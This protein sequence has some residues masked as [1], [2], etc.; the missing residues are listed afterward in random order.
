M[1]EESRERV[2]IDD[3]LILLM[4]ITGHGKSSIANLILDQKKF[5]IHEFYNDCLNESKVESFEHNG[6]KYKILDTPGINFMKSYKEMSVIKREI[7]SNLIK[8]ERIDCLLFVHKYG[9]GVEDIRELIDYIRYIFGEKIVENIIIVITKYDELMLRKD[10]EKKEELMRS[11]FKEIFMKEELPISFVFCPDESTIENILEPRIPN[12]REEITKQKDML[13][14]LIEGIDTP[15]QMK[16][17][18]KRKKGFSPLMNELLDEIMNNPELYFKRLTEEE[19]SKLSLELKINLRLVKENISSGQKIGVISSSITGVS[20]ICT[21]PAI[22]ALLLKSILYEQAAATTAIVGSTLTPFVLP[23]VGIFGL[24]ATS[25]MVYRIHTRK[26]K[27]KVQTPL[28]GLPQEDPETL[29]IVDKLHARIRKQQLF[30]VKGAITTV[31]NVKIEIEI[32]LTPELIQKPTLITYLRIAPSQPP[33]H[34]IV[35]ENRKSCSFEA[36]AEVIDQVNNVYEVKEKNI[37]IHMT[38]RNENRGI[39]GETLTELWE[40]K[41]KENEKKLN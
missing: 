8:K 29:S 16:N 11:K 25:Y 1:V 2:A 14:K 39:R 26:P 32:N 36:E 19:D 20:G 15:Y 5:K 4:G 10:K 18:L 37:T 24:A 34:Y 30:I 38:Y 12:I 9:S 27:G 13:M 41:L 6:K 33:H 3:K 17:L 23:V 7:E 21:Y 28:Q 40:R 35:S 31:N 22:K